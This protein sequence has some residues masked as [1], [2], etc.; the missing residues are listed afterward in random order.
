M[1][2]II[3]IREVGE[4]YWQVAVVNPDQSGTGYGVFP[5][6]EAAEVER[7]LILLRRA[8]QARAEGQAPD[9]RAAGKNQN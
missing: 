8:A 4:R 5:T 7:D 6:R 1:T 2:T 9:P 3:V